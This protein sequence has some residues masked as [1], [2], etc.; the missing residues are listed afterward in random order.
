MLRKLDLLITKDFK[1]NVRKNKVL[2]FKLFP[3]KLEMLI[4]RDFKR[5]VHKNEALLV[6]LSIFPKYCLFENPC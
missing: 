3:V 2:L 5:N 4:T 6:M 1:W